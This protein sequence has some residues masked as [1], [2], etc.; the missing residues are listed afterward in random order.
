ME[1]SSRVS[2]GPAQ[3]RDTRIDALR[4]LAM[5]FIIMHHCIINDFGLQNFLRYDTPTVELIAPLKVL[6][7]LANA[8]VIVGVNLFFLMSGYCRIRPK[9][10]NLVKLIVKVYLIFWIIELCGILAGRVDASRE[11]LIVMLDPFDLYWFIGTYIV[12][13]LTSPLLNALVEKMDLKLF[14][15][16]LVCF[17]LIFCVYG[18]LIEDNCL[19]LNNGYSYLMAACLYV[20][21]SGLRKFRSDLKLLNFSSGKYL[22]AYAVFCLATG[23]LAMVFYRLHRYAA[24]WHC[25]AYNSPLVV[26]ASLALLLAFLN[27]RRE[28]RPNSALRVLPRSTIT[29]YLCH[30]T[31]WLT[32]LR[33]YPIVWLGS[34]V[35]YLV[36][37]L[38]L[39][40]WAFLIYAVCTVADTVYEKT[41]G[42]LGNA[43]GSLLDRFASAKLAPA[44]RKLLS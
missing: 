44:L 22:A 21:G 9:V 17:F 11:T 7:I 18:V 12:L 2:T 38:L 31:C 37:F 13:F 28:F 32:A 16:Y 10:R 24:A 26:L 27:T 43:L 23:C 42:R 40:A 25:Y 36:P 35:G 20:L 1:S 4:I 30:S 33:S 39:P 3:A 34:R 41:L 19:H 8:F 15:I 6:L 14:R 5:L 29:T